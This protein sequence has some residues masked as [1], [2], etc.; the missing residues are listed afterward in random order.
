MPWEFR[1][2]MLCSHLNECEQGTCVP[3]TEGFYL[4]SYLEKEIHHHPQQKT[5]KEEKRI[6]MYQGDLVL[7]LKSHLTTK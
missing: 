2:G 7:I 1:E 4:Y 3:R 5:R 6:R